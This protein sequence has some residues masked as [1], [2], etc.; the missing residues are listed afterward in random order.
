MF[1]VKIFL[2]LYIGVISLMVC[3]AISE[4]AFSPDKSLK[5]KFKTFLTKIAFAPFYPLSLLS[6]QGR[7]A[8]INKIKNI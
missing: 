4:F 7:I 2:I 8:F 3:H 5:E 6:K 1:F